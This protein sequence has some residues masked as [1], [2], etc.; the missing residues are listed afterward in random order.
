M[1]IIPVRK[2]MLCLLLLLSMAST[3]CSVSIAP[4]KAVSDDPLETESEDPGNND[5]ADEKAAA[6]QTPGN[7][8]A[9][10]EALIGF[11]HFSAASSETDTVSYM[12]RSD[13][14]FNAFFRNIYLSRVEVSGFMVGKYQTAR[15]KIV[16]HDVYTFSDRSRDTAWYEQT[17]GENSAYQ[18]M[19]AMEIT[20]PEEYRESV[21]P[22]TF[23]YEIIKPGPFLILTETNGRETLLASKTATLPFG[24][25]EE[26]DHGDNR[27]DIMLNGETTSVRVDWQAL[28]FNIYGGY[29]QWERDWHNG[30][31]VMREMQ[32]SAVTDGD[33]LLLRACAESVY[34]SENFEGLNT[35]VADGV[36]PDHPCTVLKIIGW[37]EDVLEIEGWSVLYNF[38]GKGDKPPNPFMSDSDR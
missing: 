22:F 13:G 3:A 7:I 28:E 2:F 6:S 20:I 14:S 26:T 23:V 10:D 37:D 4:T 9:N 33:Y 32:G 18:P 1:D 15:G 16:C 31:W 19:D 17:F 38:E 36:L 30:Q 21:A 34:E 12:F 27:R 5:Y 35:P 11:W 25:W 24:C 29:S 8:S